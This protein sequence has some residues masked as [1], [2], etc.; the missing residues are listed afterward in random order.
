MEK[1]SLIW[2]DYN[3]HLSELMRGMLKRTDLSDVTLVC[4]ESSFKVHKVV[5]SACSEVF[6]EIIK[7]TPGSN[8]VIYLRGIPAKQMEILVEFMYLGEAQ[9]YDGQIEDFLNIARDLKIK[10]TG[11]SDNNASMENGCMKENLDDESFKKTKE[12]SKVES[13]KTDSVIEKQTV[14]M[15]KTSWESNEIHAVALQRTQGSLECPECGRLFTHGGQ[16]NLHIKSIHL[17]IKHQCNFCEHKATQKSNL[18]AHVKARHPE[19]EA[20]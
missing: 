19:A 20:L 6:T 3:S 2:N 14:I 4:D 18:K 17:G 9:M 11:L 7:Q 12:P 1:F 15:K 10:G 16:L 5:L 8:S 13:F